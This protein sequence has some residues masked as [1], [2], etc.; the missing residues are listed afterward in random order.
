MGYHVCFASGH[1]EKQVTSAVVI[2]RRHGHA[3]GFG[4]CS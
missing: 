2:R 3:F 1:N 4:G